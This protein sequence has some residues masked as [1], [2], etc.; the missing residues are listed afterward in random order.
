[1][2]EANEY[3]AGGMNTDV[4]KLR[5]LF[6]GS[7]EIA[8]PTL[9]RL[10]ARPDL[11]VVAVVTQ[12]DR[13]RGRRLRTRAC[14]VKERAVEAGLTVLDPEKV[15]AEAAVE[16][17]AAL[18]P[19]LIVVVAYGQYISAKVLAIPRLAAINLH[20]SLLP[21]Y[22]GAAPIQ[23]AVAEGE[24]E[25]GVTILHV[26][27][28]MDAGDIILQ[29]KVPIDDE[30]TSVTLQVRLAR[31]GAEVMLE[32]IDGLAAGM[33][34]RTPQNEAET[35]YV[36]KLSKEDGYLDWSVSAETLRNRVRGFQPWPGCSCVDPCDPSVRL[37][38]IE[39]RVEDGVGEPGTVLE[40]GK[41][42]PLVAAGAKAL[43]LL[44]VQPPGKKAMDG[45]AYLRG[46]RLKA[47]DRLR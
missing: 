37:K 39:V 3:K 44:T 2:P 38:V 17:I 34:S 33:A 7:D 41:A 28:E 13:P 45:G 27:K 46:Y 12:P 16:E 24:T 25:T 42:G 47:G 11:E 5:I 14:F 20:P 19:D 35:V 1:M 15:G 4:Q 30:D 23:M 10:M 29:E 6:M 36:S 21:K 18:Q 31:R 22:R 43:R 26:S 40:C 32:A 8:C 9:E